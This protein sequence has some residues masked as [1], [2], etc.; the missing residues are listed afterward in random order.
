MLVAFQLSIQ[1]AKSEPLIPDEA[2][3][4]VE[5][6]PNAHMFWWFYGA[7]VKD[8]AQRFQK[9][10]LMWLQGGPGASSTGYGNFAEIGPLDVGLESRN[11]TWIREANIVFVDNPVGCGYSYVKDPSALTRNISEIT[12]DLVTFFKAFLLK[13]PIFQKIPFFI[14]GE[15]YGG[16]MAAAFGK[17][18]YILINEKKIQCKLNGLALGDSLISFEDTVLSYGLYLFSFSLLDGKDYNNVQELATETS[19]AASKGDFKTAMDLSDKGNKLIANVTDNVD[20]YYVLRHNVLDSVSAQ[21]H[22]CKN[23]FRLSHD[24]MFVQYVIR[25]HHDPLFELMNGPIRKKL[26]IIP[27]NVTWGGQ[28]DL[29]AISQ[30]NDIPSS[31]LSDVGELVRGGVKVIVYEGQL[32]M[33]CGTVGPELWISKL[34]WDGMPEFLKASRKPLYAPSKLEKRETGAFL[35]SYKNFGLYYILNAGHMVPIDAPEMALEM[36]KN[37]LN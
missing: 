36:I 18:L 4:Y 16:K 2:W 32:D 25:A 3:D 26:G 5:V 13:F 17:A 8:P 20:V 12:A 14:A 1:A 15:S 24:Q 27:E 19:S 7:Q 22:I 6:R 35:K 33:I 37:V 21:S 11:T 31:V 10:L 29:V 28:S 34:Q 23:T 9:P 30:R